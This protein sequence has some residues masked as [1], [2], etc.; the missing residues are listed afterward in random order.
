[1][2]KA[3]LVGYYGMQNSGDDALL[4]ATVMGAKQFLDVDD[5]II[6]TPTK[7]KMRGIDEAKPILLKKQYFPAQNRLRQYKAAYSSNRILIGGGS[8][9]QNQRDIDLKRDLLILAGGR[10]HL[11]L[12]VGIGPFENT[13]AEHSCAKLLNRLDFTGVRDDISL[14]IAN[15]I[16]PN[17]NVEKTF[18]LAP[19]LLK[20]PQFSLTS[21]ER[22]GIAVCL[23]PLERLKGDKHAEYQRLKSIANALTTLYFFYGEPIVFLD[24]NGHPELGD[25]AIHKEV[26]SM[27]NSQVEKQFVDYDPNPY[28]L[29]QRIASYKTVVSMRLHGTIFGFMANTPVI[30][31]NYHQKCKGWCELIGMPKRLQF[32]CNEISSEELAGVIY[33]GLGEG[34]SNNTISI[35]KAVN[36]SMKNWRNEYVISNTKNFRSYSA[37]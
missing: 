33:T 27:M 34:F 36:A 26:A 3:Y 28:R 21:M 15:D 20:T 12:G 18:D 2:N 24:F 31:I 17:A 16:A 11:A 23:C 25:R 32:D 10:G 7:I 30:S 14:E 8:V 37:I 9:I 4:A 29:L 13:A 6:N 35:D 5:I 1:M 19:S 22:R